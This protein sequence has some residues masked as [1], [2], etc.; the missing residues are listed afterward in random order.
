MRGAGG[1]ILN[2][3]WHE[4]NL[5]LC[6]TVCGSKGWGQGKTLSILHRDFR[7]NIQYLK[8]HEG[9]K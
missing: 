1:K 9:L 8:K 3:K 4:N 6:Y 7:R 2:A 5:A